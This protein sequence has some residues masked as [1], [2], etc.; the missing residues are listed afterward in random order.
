MQNNFLGLIG[1]FCPT[2]LRAAGT[3]NAVL[4]A[5]PC[6]GYKLAMPLFCRFTPELQFSPLRTDET[7]IVMTIGHVF[8]PTDLSFEFLRLLLV[9]VGGLDETN[10]SV[11]RQ[12][13]VVFQTFISRV[14][15]ALFIGLSML[16]RQFSHH[17]TERLCVAA[18]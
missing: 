7:V 2:A 17:G 18:V 11:L 9:V 16:L 14:R 5:V 12:M 6:G 15:D 13:Q 8:D 3:T 4:A 10:L 1:V